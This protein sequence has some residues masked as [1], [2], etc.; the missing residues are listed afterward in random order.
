LPTL[1]L[2]ALAGELPPLAAPETARDFVYAEDVTTA[3]L[4]AAT[5]DAQEPDAVYNIGSGRQTTLRDVVRVARSALTIPTEPIWGTMP[6]RRWDTTTWVANHERAR[7]V[8]GWEPRYA[9]E[10]GFRAMVD[11]FRQRPDLARWYIGQQTRPV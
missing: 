8:L 11:W 3:Y 9:F 1:A 6:N 10:E 2:R 7:Q 5:C 4:L